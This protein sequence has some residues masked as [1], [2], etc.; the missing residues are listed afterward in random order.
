M[1]VWESLAINGA[2][3]IR[4]KDKQCRKL[5]PSIKKETYSNHDYKYFVGRMNMKM[6]SFKL[7]TLSWK[8]WRGYTSSRYIKEM[9]IA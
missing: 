5:K 9:I 7:A 6:K 3:Y 2:Y 8:D 1:H 4:K